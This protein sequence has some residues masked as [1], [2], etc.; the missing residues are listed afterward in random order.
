MA[1]S[2]S[3]ESSPGDDISYLSGRFPREFRKWLLAPFVNRCRKPGFG[4]R[5]SLN[6]VEIL[7]VQTFKSAKYLQRDRPGVKA[8]KRVLFADDLFHFDRSWLVGPGLTD[9]QETKAIKVLL[10]GLNSNV[11]LSELDLGFHTEKLAF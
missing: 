10:G 4:G 6:Q 3:R 2:S 9:R 11:D 8:K 5:H 1:E 7:Q